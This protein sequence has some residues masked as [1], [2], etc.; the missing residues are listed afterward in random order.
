MPFSIYDLGRKMKQLQKTIILFNSGIDSTHFLAL[1]CTN[2][3]YYLPGGHGG[4]DLS[5]NIYPTCKQRE[6]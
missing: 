3:T 5:N 2:L 4:P 6:Y 1:Q